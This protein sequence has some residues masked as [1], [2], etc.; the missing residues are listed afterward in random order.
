MLSQTKHIPTPTAF[1]QGFNFPHAAP[2]P[3][4]LTASSVKVITQTKVFIFNYSHYTAGHINCDRL[5]V[6]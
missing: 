3:Y 4:E 1:N 5:P 2:L 6:I